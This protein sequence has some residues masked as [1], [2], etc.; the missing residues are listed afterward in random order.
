MSGSHGINRKC[1]AKWYH[2]SGLIA[3]AVAAM[4]LMTGC[5]G[6]KVTLVFEDDA[7]GYADIEISMSK[8][9][10]ALGTEPFP[11]PVPAS[12]SEV[13]YAFESV[14]GVTIENVEA[15]ETLYNRVVSARLRFDDFDALAGSPYFPGT[16]SSLIR[17]LGHRTLRLKIG[18]QGTEGSPS[19]PALL[20]CGCTTTSNPST[21]EDSPDE[22][23]ADQLLEGYEIE[24]VIT[25][26]DRIGSAGAGTLSADGRSVTL[27]ID[28]ADYYYMEK[29]SVVTVRW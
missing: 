14:R 10:L 20:D 28:T 5:L 29:P 6:L 4:V 3:A 18:P 19:D 16:G 9:A 27:R 1:T 7:G 2:R 17:L 22:E 12:P 23:L 24:Y 25:V 11:H 8:S 15:S 26:P 13:Y 21:F